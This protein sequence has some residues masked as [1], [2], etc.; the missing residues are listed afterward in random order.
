MLLTPSTPSQYTRRGILYG[1]GY[2]LHGFR[3]VVNT[4][5]SGEATSRSAVRLCSTRKDS[6]EKLELLLYGKVRK[7]GMQS[8]VRM[9]S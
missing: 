6:D 9:V 7:G 2:M 8:A 4:Q 3:S 1:M 5:K